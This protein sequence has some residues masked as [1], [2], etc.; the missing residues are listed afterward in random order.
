MANAMIDMRRRQKK[1]E[2][3]FGEKTLTLKGTTLI[4]RFRCRCFSKEIVPG[5]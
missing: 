3:A 4:T 1:S 5:N 2:Y